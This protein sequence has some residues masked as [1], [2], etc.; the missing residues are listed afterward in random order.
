MPYVSTMEIFQDGLKQGY[1][2]PMFNCINYEMIRWAIEAAEEVGMPVLIGH[3]FGFETN[4][5]PAVAEMVTKYY[6]SKA[7]VPVAFHLDH[8][9]TAEI[10]I[11]R[12]KHFD[13]VMI[14][15]SHYDFEE[16]VRLTKEVVD[17]AHQMG[18]V[19][20]AELGKVGNAGNA[21]DVNNPD[22][23][24]D[25]KQAVE[26]VERTGCD[27]LAIAIGTSHGAYKFKPGT[28]PQLRF[29]IL[30]EVSERLPGFPIVLHGSSSV[31]QEYVQMI[32][33]FGGAMPG[34]IGVPEDQL[35]QAARLAVCKINIDS[36]LRLAMT[37]TIRKY[38]AE[39]P[40][41]FDPRKYLGPAREN[42]KQLV[43]HKIVDVLGCDGKA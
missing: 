40:A 18:I 27:S 22:N 39:H 26:F 5:D 15:G 37:G 12:M 35:R 20:E 19:V 11:S 28:K 38:L 31:P 8:C 10:C 41:E 16:N 36:D 7:K 23:Y 32:N 25:V 9:P 6:A 3:Y 4:M 24:T 43:K 17:I 21:N 13:S 1:G 14:D 33:E 42:I 2:T 29:D 34:A 30:E